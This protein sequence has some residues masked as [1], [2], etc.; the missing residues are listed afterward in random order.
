MQLKGYPHAHLSAE[1][2]VLKRGQSFIA[3]VAE[4]A[5]VANTIKVVH[6]DP[7]Y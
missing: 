4:V 5:E 7:K 2:Q 1:S 6:K 3:E